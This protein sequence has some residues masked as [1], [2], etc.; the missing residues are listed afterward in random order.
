MWAA[1]VAP[2]EQFDVQLANYLGYAV[3]SNYVHN[4]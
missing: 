4:V 2:S 1:T 3:P